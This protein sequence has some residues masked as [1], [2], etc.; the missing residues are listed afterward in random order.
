M[1]CE[2]TQKSFSPYL[3]GQLARAV[4]A[5]ADAHLEVCPVC[6]LELDRA[7]ALMRSLANLAPPPPPT[8]LAASISDLLLV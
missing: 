1:T 2:E 6:R 5:Q 8:G 7:R 3:D 4:R